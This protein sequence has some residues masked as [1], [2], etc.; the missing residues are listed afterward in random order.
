MWVCSL[1]DPSQPGALVHFRILKSAKTLS[2][3]SPPSSGLG[4]HAH[5]SPFPIAQSGSETSDKTVGKEDSR[6]AAAK[7]VIITGVQKL[8]KR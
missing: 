1:P 6:K 5:A 7:I 8:M 3:S 4:S 2:D